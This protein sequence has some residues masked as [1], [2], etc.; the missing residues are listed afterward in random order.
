MATSIQFLV[1]IGSVKRDYG[2][3]WSFIFHNLIDFLDLKSLDFGHY[4]DIQI[5]LPLGFD[6]LI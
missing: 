1:E 2:K 6:M 5:G 4:S 3:G